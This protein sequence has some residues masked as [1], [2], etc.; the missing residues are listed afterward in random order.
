[1]TPRTRMIVHFAAGLA[2]VPAVAWAQ[3]D[4][5]KHD[6]FAR[7]AF[8]RAPAPAGP[9]GAGASREAPPEPP[10]EPDLAAVLVAGP[11]SAV[12]IDGTLVRIGE[13]VQGY[14]LV[15][16]HEREAVFVRNK[17]RVTIALR[18]LLVPGA[19]AATNRNERAP[20]AR[21]EPLRTQDAISDREEK[22]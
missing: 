21:P 5:L 10:W 7:P 1:M 20:A 6:P 15:E 13:V 12:N 2:C 19:P 8:V 9:A 14:Q 18:P 22:K 16:V 11:T 17:K 4:M 3:A